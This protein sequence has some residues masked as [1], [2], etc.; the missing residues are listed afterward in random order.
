MPQKLHRDLP[1]TPLYAFGETEATAVFPGPTFEA[2]TNVKVEVQWNNNIMD[3]EIMLAGDHVK[4][5]DGVPM[6]E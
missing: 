6:G 2:Q 4:L 5:W 3:P 1:P